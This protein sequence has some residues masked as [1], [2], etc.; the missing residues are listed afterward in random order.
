[1]AVVAVVLATAA[2]SVSGQRPDYPTAN[3][4][5]RRRKY[6][7]LDEELDFDILPGMPMRFSFEKL[8]ECT[9]DFSKKLGEGG[10]GS[11]FEGKIGEKRV[12]VKRLDGARQGKKEFLA[13]VE[14][15]GSIELINLVK[16]IGFCAEKSNRLLAK[17]CSFGYQTTK[18]SLRREI[19]CQLAD[20]GLSKLIDRDQSK[21]VT[22]MRGTPGY[23]APEWLTSQVT[24]KVDVYS[25][26]VVLLEIICGRKNIDISQPEESVQL[27]NLLREKAK[28]NELIDIIDKKSTDMVSHHQEEVIKMLKLAMWCLQ[29]ESSRRPSMSMVVKVMEGAVSVENCLDYSFVNP[30]SVISAQDNPSTY[31]APPSASILSGPR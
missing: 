28:D 9:E 31:S 11:V 8:R 30:N 26:G 20:F 17:N 16:V 5:T 7:E 14:T 25:F 10:F 19:Q 1:M 23:L 12:A 6:Q 18:Y 2:P 21:V 29:N 3:L 24:E 13:E 15:I 4:S 22:V 27:I